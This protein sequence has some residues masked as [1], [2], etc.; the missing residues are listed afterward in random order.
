MQ[1]KNNFTNPKEKT[2]EN[3]GLVEGGGGLLVGKGGGGSHESS[4]ITINSF[5]I[6]KSY[7]L[8]APPA[9]FCYFYN[10]NKH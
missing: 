7:I 4:P 8:I 10:Q 1:S 6:N 3:L 2:A 9:N 5:T